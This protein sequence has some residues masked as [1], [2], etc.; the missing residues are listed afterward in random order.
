MDELVYMLFVVI[1]L[2]FF[3]ALFFETMISIIALSDF[4]NYNCLSAIYGNNNST[5]SSLHFSLPYYDDGQIKK[6]FCNA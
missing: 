5:G 3:F 2:S 1:F 6:V 4:E